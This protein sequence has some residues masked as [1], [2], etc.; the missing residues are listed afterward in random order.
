MLRLLLA[1]D[2]AVRALD[3]TAD[4][5]SE[6]SYRAAF[7]VVVALVGRPG[8]LAALRRFAMILGGST[9]AL[10]A[11]FAVLGAGAGS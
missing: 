3:V 10:L 11:L 6:P 5:F 1:N 9:M 7:K 8:G 2:Q 4:L